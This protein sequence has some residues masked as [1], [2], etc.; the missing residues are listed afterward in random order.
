MK[1][2]TTLLVATAATMYFI[3]CGDAGTNANNGIM[4]NNTSSSSIGNKTGDS[5]TEKKGDYDESV[6]FAEDLPKCTAKKDEKVY[7]VEDEDITYT[8]S[9]DEDLGKGEWVKAKKK[10]KKPVADETIESEDDLPKC[11]AKKDGDIYYIEDDDVYVTCDSD[12]GKWVEIDTDPDTDKSSSSKGSSEIINTVASLSRL[13]TCSMSIEG[14][15][16]YVT[17]E[18]DYYY[19]S[20]SIWVSMVTGNTYPK[21]ESS[22]SNG[23]GDIIPEINTVSYLSSLPTCTSLMEDTYYYVTSEDDYYTCYDG[24]WWGLNSGN[25]YPKTESSSSSTVIST[26]VC[27][28]MWCGPNGDEQ[29]QTGEDAGYNL[30]GWWW[31]YNDQRNGGASFISWPTAKGNDFSDESFEPIIKACGGM[32]GEVTLN[33]VGLGYNFAGIGFNV[34]GEE[35]SETANVTSWGGIC[36]VY[37]SDIPIIVEMGLENESYYGSDLPKVTLNAITNRVIDIPWSAFE[38]AGWLDE[39]GDPYPSITG[40][41]AAMELHSLKFKFTDAVGTF[42]FNIK[43]I[44]K[45]GTCE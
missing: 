16:Y 45:Y 9:Y 23:G 27:G 22:S 11:S 38:Q 15:Y 28:D 6:E 2:L 20:G 44:G 19:C 7:Y 35:D 30:S 17:N 14:T 21:T 41:A 5:D 24:L 10:T 29:V 32:C 37:S 34:S 4:G 12:K 39:F 13:P 31:E 36:V 33:N 18:D 43:S 42:S 26:A 1:K 3:G 8:C 40:T 25:T